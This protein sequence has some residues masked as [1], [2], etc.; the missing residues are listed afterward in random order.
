MVV[1]WFWRMAFYHSYTRCHVINAILTN[2][3]CFELSFQDRNSLRGSHFV[4]LFLVI[5]WPRRE[6][7]FHQASEK[8]KIQ[9]SLLSYKDYYEK[10]KFRS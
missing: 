7:T 8:N 4:I 2:T 3:D 5:I 6:K 1:Y 9:T 10:L